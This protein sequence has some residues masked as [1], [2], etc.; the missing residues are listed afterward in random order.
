[1]REIEIEIEIEGIIE[2]WQETEMDSTNPLLVSENGGSSS[3]NINGHKPHNNISS[4]SLL[5]EKSTQT[6]FPKISYKDF[7]INLQQLLFGT[8]LSLLFPAVPLAILA[9][10]HNFGRVSN[11]CFF[12][13]LLL[14]IV[15]I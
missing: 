14:I 3:S 2:L 13:P 11:R 8:K 5:S 7:A 10:Y 1:M 4:S 15:A 12:L 9:H 6:L